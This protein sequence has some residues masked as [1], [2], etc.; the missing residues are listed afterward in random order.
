MYKF[1]IETKSEVKWIWPGQCESLGEV[2]EFWRFP[3]QVQ[4]DYK[5]RIKLLE[6]LSLF[7]NEEAH[8][9]RDTVIL[10]L[11]LN[12]VEQNENYRWLFVGDA[13]LLTEIL[14]WCVWEVE[15]EIGSLTRLWGVIDWS[16]WEKCLV[17]IAKGYIKILW[18]LES[19]RKFLCSIVA[20][21]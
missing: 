9:L 15:A 7:L 16:S 17:K 6:S 18:G 14:Y 20:F 10:E 4:R 1:L 3:R 13:V 2:H 12:M 5:G 21:K 19:E 11:W 8:L